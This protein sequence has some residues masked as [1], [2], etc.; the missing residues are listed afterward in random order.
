[1][2]GKGFGSSTFGSFNKKQEPEESQIKL[3]EQMLFKQI[4][5]SIKTQ[6]GEVKK[7][8][9]E[10][11]NQKEKDE[12]V[13]DKL[14]KAQAKLEEIH[15]KAFSAIFEDLSSL[16]RQLDSGSKTLK[17]FRKDLSL[18]KS[19]DLKN[20][21]KTQTTPFLLKYVD[22]I[23]DTAESLSQSIVAYAS[24]LQ[25]QTNTISSSDKQ[26][27]SSDN[28]QLYCFLKEQSDA[29]F[30]CSTKVS[31]LI[32]KMN[33]VRQVLSEKLKINAINYTN[34]DYITENS[35]VQSIDIKYQQFLE[36]RKQKER[37]NI[38]ES[39]IFG[40]STVSVKTQTNSFMSN[41]SIKSFGQG[42]KSNAAN[43]TPSGFGKIN[44]NTNTSTN[45]ST[46]TNT[47]TN[48]P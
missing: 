24:H 5:D 29:I 7:L 47:N 45:T 30:R 38:E 32:T 28:Q 19:I 35:N 4:P 14:S 1:M 18:S 27:N 44:T 9:D 23:E 40:K 22:D 15:S 39:D 33:Q 25:P 20:L 36:Q 31:R 34:E 2:F 12:E 21:N 48:N 13:L 26:N 46:N 37:R 11:R 42:Y 43:N 10:N 8:I 16:A 17:E 41:S 6:F 3:D